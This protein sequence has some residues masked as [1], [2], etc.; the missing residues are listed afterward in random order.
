MSLP[1]DGNRRLQRTRLSD[2]IAGIIRDDVLTGKLRAGEH[3][4]QV[5]WAE[6]LGVSRMPVRDAIT[7]LSSEGVLSQSGSGQAIVAEIDPADI[8]DG[9]YLNAVVSSLAAGRAALRITEEEIAALEAIDKSL[10]DTIDEGDLEQAAQLNWSFHR[11][12]NRAAGSQR[13]IAILRLLSTSIPHQAFQR[14]GGWPQHAVQ[15]HKLILQ[16]LRDKDSETATHLMLEHV[17][18]GSQP[19]LAELEHTRR[20]PR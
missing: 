19:M 10:R 13:L 14:L 9:Y 4:G 20:A 8:R 5:E 3:I 12:I 1:P 6:R 2:Q 15:D 18:A 17:Q 16:A 11:A 7:Q